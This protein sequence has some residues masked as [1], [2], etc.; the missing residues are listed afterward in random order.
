MQYSQ[1]ID[2]VQ[3]YN[4]FT[5]KEADSALR[6][7]VERLAARLSNGERK[8]LASQ[9]PTE[10]KELA[11]SASHTSNISPEDFYKEFAESQKLHKPYAKVQMQA[12]WEVLREALGEKGKEVESQL[13]TMWLTD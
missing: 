13:P 3:D 6:Y 4:G 5:E 11:L 7:F 12:V 9:L 2:R 1:M 8:D 10:L